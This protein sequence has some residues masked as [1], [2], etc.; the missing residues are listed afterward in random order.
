MNVYSGRPG[1]PF[2]RP[3]GRWP[4]GSGGIGPQTESNGRPAPCEGRVY[5]GGW[6]HTW[7]RAGTAFVPAG[8]RRDE[9]AEPVLNEG[10]RRRGEYGGWP[11]LFLAGLLRAPPDPR[12]RARV[13]AERIDHFIH[14]RKGVRTGMWPRL[15]DQPLPVWVVRHARIRGGARAEGRP[16]R[17]GRPN[18]SRRVCGRLSSG[19]GFGAD[20][21]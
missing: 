15:E 8:A 4:R 21:D 20:A 7:V 1:T 16:L 12:K 11:R 19:P 9:Q 6:A 17:R 18:E 14:G 3:A 5:R 13:T 2:F 10:P